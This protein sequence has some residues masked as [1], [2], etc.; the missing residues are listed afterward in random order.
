MWK[1]F[2]D[3]LYPRSCA[4]CETVLVKN[5]ELICTSCRLD[6]PTTDYHLFPDNELSKRFYGKLPIAHTMAYLKFVKKG[7]AQKIIHNLKYHGEEKISYQFGRW[8]GR[9]LLKSES[10]Q[11]FDLIAPVPLHKKRLGQ[12]GY[13]QAEGFAQG[14]SEVLDIPW[15]KELLIRTVASTTQTKKRSF[16][17]WLNVEKIFEVAQPALVLG[18]HVLLVDDVITTGATFE[19]CAKKLLDSQC[20]KVSIAAIAAA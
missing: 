14:L 19:A 13:N 1:D 7:K 15:S 10:Y 8:Y 18:K 2:V 20:G 4:G 16:E 3:M 17:R 5:E 9:E 6:L 11:Q 12:R